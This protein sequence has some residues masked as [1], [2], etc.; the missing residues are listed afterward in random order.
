[1]KA[2]CKPR[3][4]ATAISLITIFAN[5]ECAR[6]VEAKGLPGTVPAITDVA[7]NDAGL[8]TGRV[9]DRQGKAIRNAPVTVLL[10][11]DIVC[12]VKTD[13][14]GNF[15]VAGLKGGVYRVMTDRGAAVCRMW[16]TATAPPSARKSILIVTQGPVASGNTAIRYWLSQPL[17]AI[18]IAAIAVSA[19]KLSQKKDGRR[20]SS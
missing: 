10:H 2:V 15:H 3:L 5:G 1:M 18:S 13:L 9:V 19:Y 4:V 20:N 7:L 14:Q 17:V 8:F 11:H 16:A 6:A 12:Q